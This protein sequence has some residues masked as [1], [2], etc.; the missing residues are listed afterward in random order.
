LALETFCSGWSTPVWHGFR[1]RAVDGTPFRLP[2]VEALER[3]FG[4]RENGP[5]LAR[6]SIL[7]DIGHDLVLDDQA[8]CVDLMGDSRRSVSCV[9]KRGR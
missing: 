5:T 2:P 6:G 4:A 8:L 9:K 3:A 1:L 7:Y